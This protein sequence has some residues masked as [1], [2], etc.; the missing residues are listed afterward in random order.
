MSSLTPEILATSR[1]YVELNFP[2]SQLADGIFKECKNVQFSQDVIEICEVTPQKW[3]K[4]SKGRIIRTKIPGNYQINNLI[5]RRGMMANSIA[6]WDWMLSV[7]EG[8]W[9]TK[10]VASG[11]LSIRTQEDLPGA[12]YIFT[13][14]WPVRYSFSDTDAAANALAFEELEIAVEEFKRTT[15]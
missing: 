1:F 14:A 8:N 9:A 12:E 3:G 4:A 2:G 11:K 6:M 15:G 5:F 7:Q 10:S 13:N